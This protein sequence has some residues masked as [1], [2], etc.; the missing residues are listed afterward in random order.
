MKTTTQNNKPSDNLKQELPQL[1]SVTDLFK[2][3]ARG[4]T[5]VSAEESP[6]YFASYKEN[7]EEFDVFVHFKYKSGT[8]IKNLLDDKK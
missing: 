3:I 8:G 4:A 7:G 2:M 1:V 5:I 6:D